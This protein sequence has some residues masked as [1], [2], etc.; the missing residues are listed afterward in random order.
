MPGRYFEEWQVGD[1]VAH[2]VTRTVTEADNVL[3]LGAYPQPAAD[4]PRP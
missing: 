3:D 2:A 4:A 1:T